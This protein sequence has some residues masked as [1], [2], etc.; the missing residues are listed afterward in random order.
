MKVWSRELGKI[1][2]T[3]S[4]VEI[5]NENNE[6]VEWVVCSFYDPELPFGSQWSWGHYFGSFTDACL[7]VHEKEMEG[8]GRLCGSVPAAGHGAGHPGPACQACPKSTARP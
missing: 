7:Y 4:M 2:K 5:L 3:Q 1:N 6:P 8:M